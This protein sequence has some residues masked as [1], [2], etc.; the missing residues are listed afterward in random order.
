MKISVVTLT[1]NELN[2]TKKHLKSLI[3][4]TPLMTQLI[5]VDAPHAPWDSTPDTNIITRNWLKQVL[6]IKIHYK[7][8]KI[9]YKLVLL[10]KPWWWTPALNRGLEACDKDSKYIVF[11]NNDVF[12]RSGWL[13]PIIEAMEQD[14]KIGWMSPIQCDE[15][16]IPRNMGHNSHGE[17][18]VFNPEQ[19]DVPIPVVFTGDAVMVFR[20]ETLNNV[21]WNENQC[22]YFEYTMGIELWKRGWKV[23]VHPKSAVIHLVRFTKKRHET[24]E[25][26]QWTWKQ[27]F[28]W[29]GIEYVDGE[30]CFWS[31]HSKE[32]VKL[33]KQHII[34][35]QR[36]LGI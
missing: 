19:I 22:E 15:K 33:I 11:L 3:T 29:H 28:E 2:L 9:N 27:I 7:K 13:E 14:N 8:K 18:I 4:N 17:W 20:R 26:K 5:V 36:K 35:E 23:M 6:P 30:E 24:W 34:S 21:G 16:W 31:K 25:P 1:Y 10:C 32:E 12:F